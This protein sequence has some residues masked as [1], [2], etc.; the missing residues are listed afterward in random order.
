MIEFLLN[1]NAPGC[2]R[3]RVMEL[4]HSILEVASSHPGAA[5]IFDSNSMQKM[6]EYVSRGI[7]YAQSMD[8]EVSTDV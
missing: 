5:D 1:R 2:Q 8:M 3:K 6:N 4:K 7:F